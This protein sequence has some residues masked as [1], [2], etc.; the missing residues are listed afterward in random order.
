MTAYSKG[1]RVFLI[2]SLTLMTMGYDHEGVLAPVA[3]DRVLTIGSI[4]TV[5]SLYISVAED[6]ETALV[7]VTY[8]G[9]GFTVLT[10]EDFLERKE[11]V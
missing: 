2:R 11:N 5:G 1:D 8:D 9:C 10:P 6:A 4:G 7:V 3:S